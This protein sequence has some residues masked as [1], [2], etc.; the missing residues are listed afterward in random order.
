MGLD[1]SLIEDLYAYQCP[2]FHEAGHCV[3]NLV[4][5]ISVQSVKIDGARG[6][7]KR[8][9]DPPDAKSDLI[10][11][12]AGPLAEVRFSRRPQEAFRHA[13]SNYDYARPRGR[14]EA[15]G[16]VSAGAGL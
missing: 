7:T 3:V 10:S 14:I 2:A 5:G 6:L 16:G 12:L 1:L 4:L 8:G 15:R 13:A 9:S 11:T